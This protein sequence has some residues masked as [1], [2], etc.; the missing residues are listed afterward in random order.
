M[1]REKSQPP[2][3]SH[4]QLCA[5]M[6]IEILLKPQTVVVGPQ[7]MGHGTF[8]FAYLVERLREYF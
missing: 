1:G 2:F 5:N 6:L 7:H 3:V 4:M 8:Q